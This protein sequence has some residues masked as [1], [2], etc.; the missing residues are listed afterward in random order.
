MVLKMFSVSERSC[1]RIMAH[2]KKM[3]FLPGVPDIQIIRNGRAYFIELKTETGE[4]KESQILFM[5]N[6]M[7]AGSKCAVC[8]SLDSMEGV[9]MKWGIVV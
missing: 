1:Y 5:N 7:K 3:G 2:L 4:L 6:A 9:L 8:R